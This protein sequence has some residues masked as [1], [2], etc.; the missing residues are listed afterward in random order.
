[1]FNDQHYA[2]AVLAHSQRRLAMREEKSMT[3]EIG[4]CEVPY[5]SALRD[6]FHYCRFHHG[7]I[8]VESQP[9]SDVRCGLRDG[10]PQSA[11][12]PAPDAD[13]YQCD[14]CGKT[15][16][17]EDRRS[18]IRAGA[19]GTFCPECCGEKSP[20]PDA[21]RE[22]RYVGDPEGRFGIFPIGGKFIA[23]TD[24][25]QIAAQIVSD[26]RSIPLLVEAL[27]NAF[28]HSRHADDCPLSGVKWRQ[29]QSHECACWMRNAWAQKRMIELGITEEEVEET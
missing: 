3:T 21:D 4:C 6:C 13:T 29:G 10:D 19:E 26:H 16:S 11:P 12:Q 27:S 1:M 24:T 8:C 18:G 2:N 25:E 9:I 23:I 22:W 17:E 28:A 7:R 14:A 15:I 5:C 20:A